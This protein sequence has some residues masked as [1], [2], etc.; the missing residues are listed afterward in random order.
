MDATERSLLFES[1][2]EDYRSRLFSFA[3]SSLKKLVEDG[4]G[5]PA[6]LSYCGLLTALTDGQFDEAAALCRRAIEK[7][8]RRSSELYLNLGRVLAMGRR[9][10][11]AIVA[12]TEGLAL[13]PEDRRLRSELRHL[14]PRAKPV[15]RSLPRRHPLNKY[16]GIVRTMGARLWVTFIPQVRRRRGRAQL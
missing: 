6:H 1:A 3:A 11:E 8:G 4:S 7:D 14:V 10:G 16:V 2:M 12:L 15:F 5:D 9:R 13:H